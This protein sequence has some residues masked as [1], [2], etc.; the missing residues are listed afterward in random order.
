MGNGGREI[1]RILHS[2]K[3][4]NDA[5]HV[6][7]YYDHRG[8]HLLKEGNT[9]KSSASPVEESEETQDTSVTSV[10]DIHHGVAGRGHNQYGNHH[11]QRAETHFDNK[12]N[13]R[14]L[15][16]GG[17]VNNNNV[18]DNNNTIS[19]RAKLRQQQEYIFRKRLLMTEANE[20]IL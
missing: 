15:Y 6:S 1:D 12:N 2:S 7:S 13:N 20:T 19:D 10:Y 9:R 17:N 3:N 18:K 4:V 5:L 11:K 14:Q 8:H 16:K